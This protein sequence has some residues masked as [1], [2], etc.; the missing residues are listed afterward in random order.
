MQAFAESDAEVAYARVGALCE[1]IKSELNNDLK[2]HNQGILPQWINLPQ[3]AAGEY[4][5][6][7]TRHPEKSGVHNCWRLQASLYRRHFACII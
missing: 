6:V 7:I 4:C 1:A 5:R 3:V 2:I